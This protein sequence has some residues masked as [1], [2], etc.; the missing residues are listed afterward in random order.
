MFLPC[1]CVFIAFSCILFIIVGQA[2]SSH[3]FQ[4]TYALLTS[5]ELL[6][7]LLLLVCLLVYVVVVV[8]STGWGSWSRQIWITDQQQRWNHGVLKFQVQGG[9]VWRQKNCEHMICTTITDPLQHTPGSCAIF[10]AMMGGKLA[11]VL[12][13]L[14]RL[15]INVWE[16]CPWLAAVC[17]LASIQHGAEIADTYQSAN[18]VSCSRS[19]E[20]GYLLLHYSTQ[21]L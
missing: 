2:I 19:W 7:L 20:A 14:Q 16:R 5:S 12:I 21:S 17:M 10:L 6:V 13:K 18:Q 1:V 15:V 8:V 9:P 11:I 3:R 4:E